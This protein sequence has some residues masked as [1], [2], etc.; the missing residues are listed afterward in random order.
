MMHKLPAMSWSRALVSALSCIA[1]MTTAVAQ[2][3][4]DAVAAQRRI[5][6]A[7]LYKFGAYITWPEEMFPSADS[8]FIIGVAGDDTMADELTTLVTGRNINGRNIVV[9]RVHAGQNTDGIHLLFVAAGTAQGDSLVEAARDKPTVT[10]TEGADG[11][12]HG[13]DMAFVLID[14][15]VRFDVALDVAQRDGVKISSQ[16]LSVAYSVSGAKP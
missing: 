15:R 3:D 7:Y 5:E 2:P 14:D 16:L 11:L 9:R 13:A 6:A 1:V 4:P 10:V 8:P 12:E